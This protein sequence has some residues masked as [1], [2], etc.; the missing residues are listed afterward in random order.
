MQV[1]LVKNEA[2]HFRSQPSTIKGLHHF[3]GFSD[4]YCWFIIKWISVV[5][6]LPSPWQTQKQSPCHLPPKKPSNS[7]KRPLLLY[8]WI[9]IQSSLSLRKW[10]PPLPVSRLF[11]LLPRIIICPIQWTL[12]NLIE[13]IW[14]PV[15][16][17][18]TPMC[19]QLSRPN[20]T[21]LSSFLHKFSHP[22]ISQT[23]SL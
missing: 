10:M 18:N 1:D 22:G 2:V 13:L 14:H 17:Q 9:P 11:W 20:T 3:L 7:S 23:L 15:T 5:A 16:V 12:V 19:W 6:S 8:Y 4:F 21:S